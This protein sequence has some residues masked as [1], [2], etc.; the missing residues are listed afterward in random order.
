MVALGISSV[1]LESK[2]E[3]PNVC[4]TPSPPSDALGDFCLFLLAAKYDL[5]YH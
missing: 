4:Q 1:L 3:L 2:Q 5:T